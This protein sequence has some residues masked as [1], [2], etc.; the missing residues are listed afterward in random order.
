MRS[1]HSDRVIM[2]CVVCVAKP[3][4]LL[5]E[6]TKTQSTNQSTHPT[7]HP[8]TQVNVRAILEGMMDRLA[9]FAESNPD[10]IPAD[11]KCVAACVLCGWRAM[12]GGDVGAGRMVFSHKIV[13][14][15]SHRLHPTPEPD[16]PPSL[17]GRSTC[18]T[19]A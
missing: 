11:L 9:A 5:R 3:P 1:L 19:P 14:R 17:P 18:S 13:H 16:P 4:P 7:I 8:P 2:W 15:T 10:S 12:G 6:P